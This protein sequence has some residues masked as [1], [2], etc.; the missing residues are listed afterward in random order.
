MEGIPPP[1]MLAQVIFGG[2]L[3][4]KEEE[5]QCPY[6]P[7]WV[8]DKG[9]D[10]FNSWDISADDSKK[11]N[12]LYEHFKNHVQPKLNPVF[13]RYKFNNEVH[14]NTTFDQFVTKLKRLSKDCSYT[15]A[16]EMIRDRIVFG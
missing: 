8:G 12:S 16:N 6:F 15:N 3:S 10:I 5:V 11:L 7:L 13:S 14:G 4:S 1:V 2:S 9:R